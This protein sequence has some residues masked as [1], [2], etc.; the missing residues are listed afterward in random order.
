MNRNLNIVIFGVGAMASLFG[1]MLSANTNANIFLFG[2][3]PE[4]I[5][6][7][8]ANG[9]ALTKL[10]GSKA[11]ISLKA[12]SQ[13]GDLPACDVALILVKAYQ[14]E[15]IAALIN[16]A[17][18]K[19]GFVVTLQNG[20]GNVEILAEHFPAERI[21]LGV[22]SQ[23]VL[24]EEAG[25]VRHT[26]DGATVIATNAALEARAGELAGVFCSAGLRAE[27]STRAES[28]A[29]GKLAVNAAVNPLTALLEIRNGQL[30]A[31]ATWQRAVRV[32]AT[33]VQ[34]VADAIG[35]ELYDRNLADRAI[36]VCRMT[37]ENRSSMLQDILRG[38]Q[39]EIDAICGSVVKAG[40]N[41]G[42]ATPLNKFLLDR[43]KAKENGSNFEP[44][45]LSQ[46][47]RI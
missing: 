8:G 12:T 46:L 29:W 38:T 25:H 16:G 11:T 9:L 1:G 4:Q 37:A 42:V 6:K 22:T 40:R 28:I 34:D 21:L 24:M 7:L 36:E 23:A 2:H 13:I 18:H 31:N 17:L 14:T 15:G 43:V 33:E 5:A 45:E 3:W 44:A 30:S 20:L 19:D 47:V 27:V 32:T 39:T 26:G 10:D 41:A 35:V